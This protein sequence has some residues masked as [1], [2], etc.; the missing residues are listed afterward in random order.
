VR[1]IRKSAFPGVAQSGS[2]SLLHNHNRK[3]K[4]LCVCIPVVFPERA[5]R[6]KRGE[7]NSQGNS[8]G[9]DNNGKDICGKVDVP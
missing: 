3:R 2:S 5:L 6:W 9:N 4:N 7:K 1:K 8:N